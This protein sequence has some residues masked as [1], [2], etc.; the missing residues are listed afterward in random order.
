M[1]EGPWKVQDQ[2]DAPLHQK[3]LPGVIVKHRSGALLLNCPA[4]NSMQ[5]TCDQLK[6]TDDKP[7]LDGP[8]HCGAGFCKRCGV[9]FAIKNGKSFVA[10][11]P[12]RDN[13]LI[14]D[15]LKNAG[16]KRPPKLPDDLR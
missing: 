9:W 8:I 12:V 5:F 2:T 14:P 13:V 15:K 10:K 4:C 16:V 6:G 3:L 1:Y 11:A 7:T